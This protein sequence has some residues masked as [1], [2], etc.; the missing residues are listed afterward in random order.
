VAPGTAEVA[1]SVPDTPG[2]AFAWK[3]A[4]GTLLRGQGSAQVAFAPGSAGTVT[5]LRV[6]ETTPGGCESPDVEAEV[7]VDFLDVPAGN[8][9]HDAVVTMAREGITSGCG[10][11]RYCPTDLV[12]RDQ[13][14]VFLLRGKH[15]GAYQPPPA[16]GAVFSDVSIATPFARWI[17]QLGME[18]VT[19]GCGLGS[20][21]PYCPSDVVT[22]D[23]MAV[24]LLRSKH[25]SAF[26]PP[27]AT[28][29]VF[30]DVHAD[31]FLARWMEQMKT[32]GL[33]SG[34]GA[35]NY[36]PSGTVTRGEMAAFIK[37]T[38]AL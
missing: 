14:A 26:L 35:G 6:R 30:A 21:P 37:R 8:L 38:F 28:G 17:E 32:D 15:G 16:T 25:G 7:V 5:T 23:Q 33:S 34:C 29:T 27:A 22:R 11:G 20:P 1:A 24:F 13:M 36:C 10:S 3:I 4:G 12:R 31:T 18:G 9:Y 19:G 2:H